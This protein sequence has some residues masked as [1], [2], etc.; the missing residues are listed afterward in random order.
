V[1]DA[2]SAVNKHRARSVRLWRAAQRA[3]FRKETGQVNT[4]VQSTP[5]SSDVLDTIP[6]QLLEQ[7][8][9]APSIQIGDKSYS[10][11]DLLKV[12]IL[13]LEGLMAYTLSP[14]VRIL[15][16]YKARDNGLK[17][18]MDKQTLCDLLGYLKNGAQL[19]DNKDILSG[20]F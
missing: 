9:A 2:A 16:A 19:E 5:T 4:P 10:R 6:P 13:F 11:E 8:A 15:A 14:D 12:C 7:V 18:G 3:H 1:L 17:L 20:M